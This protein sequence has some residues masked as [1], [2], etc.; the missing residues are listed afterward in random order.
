MD[1]VV[2]QFRLCLPQRSRRAQR[3]ALWQS[4]DD[5]FNGWVPSLKTV[6]DV[7][8]VNHTTLL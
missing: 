6:P 4:I 3:K 7:E 2:G 1:P 5:P 8:V